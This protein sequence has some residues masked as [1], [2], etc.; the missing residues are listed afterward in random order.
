VPCVNCVSRV[1]R[2][3]FSFASDCCGY[4]FFEEI[5]PRTASTMCG[6]EMP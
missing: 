6:A 2:V 4:F 5:A 3:Q 1:L